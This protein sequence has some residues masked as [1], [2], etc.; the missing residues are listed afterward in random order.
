VTIL[1]GNLN[2]AI[3][4]N[5]GLVVGADSGPAPDRFFI[6]VIQN[7]LNHRITP[8]DMGGIEHN[9]NPNY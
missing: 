4:I 6:C 2:L 9:G 7:H 5:F 8:N 1:Q 3:E